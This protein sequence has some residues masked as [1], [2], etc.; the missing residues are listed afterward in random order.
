MFYIKISFI[1]VFI[2]NFES[3]ISWFFCHKFLMQS[4]NYIKFDFQIP[5]NRTNLRLLF[6]GKQVINNTCQCISTLKVKLQ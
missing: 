4:K 5:F 3:V 2:T 6:V 1:I